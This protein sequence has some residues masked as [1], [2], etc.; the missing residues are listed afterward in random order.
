MARY[1]AGQIRGMVAE[2]LRDSD[3]MPGTELAG[4][5]GV[6]RI[7]MARHLDRLASE[8]FLRRRG[9]GGAIL[10][11]LAP[12]RSTY[13]FPD[14][15][16]RAADDYMRLVSDLGD[17]G[18]LVRDCLQS[19]AD[20][21]RLVLEV[22]EP[23]IRGVG[24]L[25]EEGKIGSAERG[26]MR[27][28]ISG[29][30]R[31]VDGAPDPSLGALVAAT[32]PDAALDAEAAAAAYRASGWST[33]CVGDLSGAADGLL[34]TD[35]GRIIG[36]VWKRRGGLLLVAAFS[37]TTEGARLFADAAGPARKRSPF[38]RLALCGPGTGGIPGCDLGASSLGELVRWSGTAR[39]AGQGAA[40]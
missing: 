10:W 5:V 37:S 6:S 12:G 21:A 39:A 14:D 2:A 20:P 3:G 18:A 1:T 16:F 24:E 7:T 40:G 38:M 29:S 19:G 8:G 28:S 34:D 27:Q 23:A 32:D 13:G 26:L 25:Y 31:L 11:T 35:L 22:V 17:A 9:A 36:R 15:Y 30:L 33:W 4:R